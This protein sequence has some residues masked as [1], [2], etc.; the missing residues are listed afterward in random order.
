MQWAELCHSLSGGGLQSRR[1]RARERGE[2]LQTP[3]ICGG[4]CMCVRCAGGGQFTQDS[5]AYYT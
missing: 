5:S 3:E 4:L 2:Q 1:E